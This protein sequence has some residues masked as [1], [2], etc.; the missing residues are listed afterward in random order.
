MSVAAINCL[1]GTLG[2]AFVYLYS[3]AL[4]KQRGRAKW[5][6][7]NSLFYEEYAIERISAGGQMRPIRTKA[8]GKKARD[9]DEIG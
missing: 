3:F 2:V 5:T 1:K 8:R 4:H 9:R 6:C 7:M